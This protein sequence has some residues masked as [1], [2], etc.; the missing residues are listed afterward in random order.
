MRDGDAAGVNGS[1]HGRSSERPRDGH[2]PEAIAQTR[3]RISPA[4]TRRSTESGRLGAAALL[5]ALR[6]MTYRIRDVAPIALEVSTSNLMPAEK[7]LQSAGQKEV[8]K[9]E[10]YQP[11]IDYTEG[12]APKRESW[13]PVVRG[14]PIDT[15][16]SGHSDSRR[17][18]NGARSTEPVLKRLFGR[19]GRRQHDA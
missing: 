14:Y 7:R 12:Y 13:V 18:P 6:R 9:V 4:V 8:M 15:F 17:A 19:I 1:R 16:Y 11:L 3:G 5:R 10:I 2:W